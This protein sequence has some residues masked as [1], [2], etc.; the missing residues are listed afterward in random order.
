M[1]ILPSNMY[2][3]LVQFLHF[4]FDVTLVQIEEVFPETSNNNK[5]L[6]FKKY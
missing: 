1:N 2:G 4:T 5:T 6:I 3:K